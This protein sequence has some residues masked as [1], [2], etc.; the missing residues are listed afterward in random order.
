MP[1]G[2]GSFTVTVPLTDDTGSWS[3]SQTVVLTWGAQSA[4][5]TILDNDVAPRR[6]RPSHPADASVAEGAALTY[7]VTLSGP[8][9]AGQTLTHWPWSRQHR[10]RRGPEPGRRHRQQWRHLEAGGVLSVPAGVTSFTLTV[11]SRG[12]HRLVEIDETVIVRV[13]GVAQPAP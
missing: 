12:R 8:A 11:P 5:G 3:P 2:V 4:T 1:A 7:T 13:G 10:R 6:S 9:A